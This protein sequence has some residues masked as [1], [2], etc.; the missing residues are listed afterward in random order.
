[1]EKII[2]KAIV[3]QQF[4]IPNLGFIAGSKV[5]EGIITR[6]AKLII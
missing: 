6:N 5:T 4:K 2:G 1:M 3:Q